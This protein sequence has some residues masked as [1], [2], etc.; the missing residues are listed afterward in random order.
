MASK[1]QV[2]VQALSVMTYRDFVGLNRTAAPFNLEDGELARAVDVSVDRNGGICTRRVVTPFVSGGMPGSPVCSMFYF[3]TEAGDSYVIFQTEDGKVWHVKN[4]PG[5]AVPSP[6]PDNVDGRCC[7]VG[8]MA[9]KNL[10]VSNGV[11]VYR[12]DGVSTPVDVTTT[13]VH[14]LGD[15]QTVNDLGVIAGCDVQ[16]FLNTIFVAAPKVNNADENSVYWSAPLLEYPDGELKGEEDFSEF[17]R[18][19]FTSGNPS[20]DIVKMMSCGKQLLVFKRHSVHS[21]APSSDA[22]I[23]EFF[24]QDLLSDSGL[25]GPKAVTCELGVAFMFD[26]RRG[27]VSIDG[28]GEATSMF[29]QLFDLIEDKEI[30]DPSK[31]AMAS[32]G[33]KLYVSVPLDGSDHNNRT[34]VYDFDVKGWVEYTLG[35]DCFMD[36][37]PTNGKSGLLGVMHDPQGIVFVDDVEGMYDI[38]T[39]GRKRISPEIATKWFDDGVPY[40]N[41][42]FNSVEA[43]VSSVGD[44]RL[45]VYGTAD[46]EP[47]LSTAVRSLSSESKVGECI[48]YDDCDTSVFPKTVREV[49]CEAEDPDGVVVGCEDDSV[50]FGPQTNTAR[51]VA[52]KIRTKAR[53]M[54]VVIADDGSDFPWCVTQLT[55]LY[56]PL[57]VR[58]C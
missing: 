30:S 13:S 3:E 39:T 56:K 43:V 9:H 11:K 14:P 10:Y 52:F 21:I 17:A 26:D 5:V 44:V 22:T 8:W 46:W 55:L 15:E 32:Y 23:A 37:C 36:Y 19:S 33:R 34:F 58:S 6:I 35:F 4:G 53:G 51:R 25:A 41:K 28:N 2:P 57:T 24:M 54:Q 16:P 50:T 12:W 47:C 49:F 42:N 40:L 38:F 7:Y 48:V 20:D 29:S 1:R 18:F 27:V 31:I 45:C